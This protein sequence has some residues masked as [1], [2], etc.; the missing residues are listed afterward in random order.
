M[1]KIKVDQVY[2]NDKKQNGEPYINKFGKAYKMCKVV[3]DGRT[4]T[5]WG[6]EQQK[7]AIKIGDILEGEIKEGEWNG[8]P[9]YE[10][11]LP[12]PGDKDMLELKEAVKTLGNQVTMLWDAIGEL[13]NQKATPGVIPNEELEDTIIAE[14]NDEDD[15]NL[16]PF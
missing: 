15:P 2:L 9:K 10:F 13:S 16:I 11:N 14:V 12:K 8:Q 7:E 3:S 4:F 6:S 5:V 1:N